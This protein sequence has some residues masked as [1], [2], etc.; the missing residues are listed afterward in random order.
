MLRLAVARVPAFL[1]LVSCPPRGV[2]PCLVVSLLCFSPRLFSCHRRPVQVPTSTSSST[3]SG[4]LA[5]L[6]WLLAATAA[7]VAAAVCCLLL[8]WL[9]LLV[10]AAAADCCCF[11]WLLLLLSSCHCCS[12]CLWLFLLLVSLLV[13]LPDMSMLLHH[14]HTLWR[15]KCSNIS[16]CR[17]PECLAVCW[18]HLIEYSRSRLHWPIRVTFFV[19]QHRKYPDPYKNPSPRNQSWLF[20]WTWIRG[21]DAVLYFDASKSPFYEKQH[22]F[23]GARG[24][25]MDDFYPSASDCISLPLLLPVL[26][27][28]PLRLVASISA[29]QV[30]GPPRTLVGDR[31][32][33][34]SAAW[35]SVVLVAPPCICIYVYLYI[36]IH[37]YMYMYIW[38][39][40]YIYIYMYICIY[41]YM[42][43]CIYLCLYV[44]MY[45]CI[46]VYMYISMF[47]N[48][49]ICLYVY[50][51]ICI[52]ICIYIYISMYTCIH[53]YMYMCMWFMYICIYARAHRHTHTHRHMHTH[54]HRHMHTHT[55]IY[56]LNSAKRQPYHIHRM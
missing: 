14:V 37:V 18:L 31:K 11:W 29:N 55:H 52:Y 44:Y 20:H 48:V 42:Y 23:R 3:R 53:V 13:L 51:C 30:L 50:M 15:E 4:P 35:A 10:A 28:I 24:R 16:C 5:C 41:V 32:G 25:M 40:V 43:I 33:P 46:H 21:S 47:V 22:W 12:C 34:D 1:S 56:R 54:T 19:Q 36:C 6:W 9:L 7:G 27:H 26:L 2:C 49:Y 45:I 8:A 17:I 39:Y 38:I